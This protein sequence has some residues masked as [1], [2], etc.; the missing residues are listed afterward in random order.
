MKYAS[1]LRKTLQKIRGKKMKMAVYRTGSTPK[2][3][4]GER[5]WVLEQH[6]V[7][8]LPSQKFDDDGPH[9]PVICIPL[10]GLSG[11]SLKFVPPCP[12]ARAE[13]LAAPALLCKRGYPSIPK[14]L[15]VNI[16]NLPV[17]LV[18]S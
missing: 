6:D 8:T 5:I 4:N 13:T 11:T 3:P 16:I 1:K 9:S 12:F 7:P 10:H 17:M 15:W 2:M 14:W 18:L